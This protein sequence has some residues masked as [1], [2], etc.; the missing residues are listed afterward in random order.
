M[1][2]QDYNI[3]VT[4]RFCEKYENLYKHILLSDSALR[5]FIAQNFVERKSGKIRFTEIGRQKLKELE[6]GFC[7]CKK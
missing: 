6:K 4:L 3:L 2:I 7:S 1:K 5:D